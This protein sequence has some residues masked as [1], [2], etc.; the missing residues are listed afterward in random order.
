MVRRDQDRMVVAAMAE[1]KPGD[2]EIL[3]LAAWEELSGPEI[4]AVLGISTSAAEQRLHR[5]KKRLANVLTEPEGST[6]F[7]PRAAEEGGG[8]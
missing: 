3:M 1:L 7:S 8:S 5:A 4:A 2:Q 6:E